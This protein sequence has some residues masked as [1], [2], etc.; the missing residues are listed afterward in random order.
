MHKLSLLFLSLP[1][2]GQ[3]VDTGFERTERFRFEAIGEADFNRI[4]RTTASR[5]IQ[6]GA[7]FRF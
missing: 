6:A 4:A 1:V 7:R 2:F 3:T 5:Q